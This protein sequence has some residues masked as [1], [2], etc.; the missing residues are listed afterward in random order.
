[1]V[2]E[3]EKEDVESRHVWERQRESSEENKSSPFS[4]LL[5]KLAQISDLLLRASPPARRLARYKTIW[6]LHLAT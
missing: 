5:A 3:I 4:P 6:P 1:M 2:G